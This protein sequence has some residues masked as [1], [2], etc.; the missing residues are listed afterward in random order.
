MEY[1]Y[2]DLVLVLYLVFT[3]AD[4]SK[5]AAK[6]K[7]KNLL[8]NVSMKKEITTEKLATTIKYQ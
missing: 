8:N 1:H 6:K 3:V 7:K 5:Y 4:L 2:D